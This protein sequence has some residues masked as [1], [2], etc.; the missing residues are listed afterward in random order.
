[1][2][3]VPAAQVACVI[4]LLREAAAPPVVLVE[5]AVPAGRVAEV[6]AAGPVVQC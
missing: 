6:G 1:M 3:A 5:M 2:P 4:G